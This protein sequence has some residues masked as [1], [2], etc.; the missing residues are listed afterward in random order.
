MRR[1]EFIARQS[2]RPN[3]FLGRLIARI[4]AKETAGANTAA[5][6]LL[7]LQPTDHVLEVGFGHG[8]TIEQVARLVP[9]GFV[10]GVDAPGV[11]AA[12]DGGPHG[13]N[14]SDPQNDHIQGKG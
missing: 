5:V 3:G 1:P 7:E 4:M 6:R 11:Q 14:Q 9:Q 12:R 2:G 8:C 13:W 10:A